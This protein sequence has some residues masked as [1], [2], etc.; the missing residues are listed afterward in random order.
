MK[1]RIR[2]IIEHY[3]L[4][5]TA[6]ASQIEV[7]KGYVSQMLNNIRPITDE[8]IEKILEAFPDVNRNWFVYGQGNITDSDLFS[9]KTINA[10]AKQQQASAP[11]DALQTN[12][13]QNIEQIEKKEKTT[14][15]QQLI[16]NSNNI[17]QQNT[18]VDVQHSK[19]TIERII[20]FYSDGTF[21]EHR[22]R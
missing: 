2:E 22:P 5:Q 12:N 18:N 17:A 1:E 19:S 15:N 6:F 4:S 3:N 8:I 9:Q 7:S 21:T 16:P 10:V 11:A 20:I 14:D 13:N